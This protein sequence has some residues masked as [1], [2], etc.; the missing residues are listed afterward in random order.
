M[1][2]GDLANLTSFVA[3]ADQRSFRGAA[4]RLG[5]T[6][7]ALSHSMRQLEER[8]GVR[9]L[10]RHDAQRIS[11]RCWPTPAPAASAGDRSNRRCPGESEPG[12]AASIGASENLCNA[13]SGRGGGGRTDMGSLLVDLPG[14]PSRTSRGRCAYRHCGG[15][16]RRWGW[17]ARPRCGGY[18]S[19]PGHRTDEDCPCW[20]AGLLRASANA[21]YPRRSHPPK[22]H[23]IPSGRRWHI[24]VAVGAEW[25]DAAG[26]GEWARHGQRR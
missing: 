7:S 13:P 2:R 8:L 9:L 15:G 20:R 10:H 21:A 17:P 16:I 5:V 18:D 3:V 14:G 22:L 26:S 12:T 6:P 19:R 25:Q 24:G 23:S 1:D 4:S 11:H